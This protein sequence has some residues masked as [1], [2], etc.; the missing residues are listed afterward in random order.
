MSAQFIT[1]VIKLRISVLKLGDSFLMVAPWTSQRYPS[2]RP[3]VSPPKLG[4]VVQG[5]A[6]L[7]I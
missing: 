2:F 4:K 6:T 7:Q 1:T 3:S 5:D